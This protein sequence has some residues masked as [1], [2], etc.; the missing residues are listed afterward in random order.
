MAASSSVTSLTTFQLSAHTKT[1]AVTLC[2]SLSLLRIFHAFSILTL[3]VHL[4]CFLSSQSIH[5]FLYPLSLVLTSRLFHTPTSFSPTWSVPQFH[6]LHSHTSCKSKASTIRPYTSNNSLI[7][8]SREI[9]YITTIITTSIPW[10][11]LSPVPFIL[12]YFSPPDLSPFCTQPYFHV[13]WR[14]SLEHSLFL[15]SIFME[16]HPFSLFYLE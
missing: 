14:L 3:H 16:S 4:R 12:F 7:F 5:P 6:I 13:S 8:T 1:L 11:V 15:I 10:L 9:A 2:L